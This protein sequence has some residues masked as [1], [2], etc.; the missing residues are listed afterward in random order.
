MI[1]VININPAKTGFFG[2]MFSSKANFPDY[3]SGFIGKTSDVI[4]DSK[5]S[6]YK[7]DKKYILSNIEGEWTNHLK[8]DDRFYWKHGEIELDQ[9]EK[10]DFMLQSDSC[11]RDDILLFR[12]GNLE[13][14]QLAKVNLEE[15]QRKD[16][17]FRDLNSKKK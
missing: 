13:L 1:A 16:K 2:K 8:F 10:Q 3:S 5:T 9:M 11:Y 17:K 12:E 14:S 6:T 4:F 15:I 7:C